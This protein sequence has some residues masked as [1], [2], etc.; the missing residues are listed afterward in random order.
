MNLPCRKNNIYPIQI[1]LAGLVQTIQRV[2]CT[3]TRGLGSR[4]GVPNIRQLCVTAPTH[5]QIW[6][7]RYTTGSSL[8]NGKNLSCGVQSCSA[9]RPAGSDRRWRMHLFLADGAYDGEPT[10]EA[11][12]ERFGSSIK[13][14]IPSPKNAI[15][16][17]NTT[18][19]LS[20]CDC[21]IAGITANGQMVW[22]KSSG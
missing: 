20:V 19:N 11:L 5:S 6:P 18:Q 17:P 8:Q 2:K 7:L 16:S 13:V 22:Q 1:T 4:Q 12:S 9:A 21:H 10:V 15:L 14:T 3:Q